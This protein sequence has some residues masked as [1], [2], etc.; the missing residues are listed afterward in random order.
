MSHSQFNT[1]SPSNNQIFSILLETPSAHINDIDFTVTSEKSALITNSNGNDEESSKAPNIS[2]YTTP[3]TLI[4]Y[5]HS[6]T[7]DNPSYL[8]QVLSGNNKP[9][10]KCLDF[11]DGATTSRPSANFLVGNVFI[12]SHGSTPTE[13][14]GKQ[15]LIIIQNPLYLAQFIMERLNQGLANYGTTVWMTTIVKITD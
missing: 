5:F 6:S 4:L 9:T 14:G 13:Y 3:N 1:L 15:I 2:E 7:Q 11:H 8:S 10:L 12:T